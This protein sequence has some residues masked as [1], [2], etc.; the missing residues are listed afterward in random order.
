MRAGPVAR[1]IFEK[2]ERADNK[3]DKGAWKGC[4]AAAH[5]ACASTWSGEAALRGARASWRVEGRYTWV[6]L[7]VIVEPVRRAYARGSKFRQGATLRGAGARKV[8]V[9]CSF[10]GLITHVSKARTCSNQSPSRAPRAATR[11]GSAARPPEVALQRGHQ[12][13][14]CSAA[15]RGG[16]AARPPEVALQRGRQ[17]WLCSR[18]RSVR[19][20]LVRWSADRPNFE[21]CAQAVY[22]GLATFYVIVNPLA[23]F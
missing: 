11:G 3:L 10:A 21:L 19:K 4:F 23:L 15:T 6:I 16:S 2:S 18:A 9:K 13:W 14:L 22:T 1:S 5:A 8:R 17:R 20:H 12:R 7:C